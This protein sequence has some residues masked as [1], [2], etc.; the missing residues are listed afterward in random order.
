MLVIVFAVA[1]TIDEAI[2]LA[3]ASDYTLT[4]AVWTSNIYSAQLVTSR[5][6]S[7]KKIFS[8]NMI[9]VIRN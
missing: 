7:G 4:A 3:N 6:R 8:V 1:D 5:V 2:T 9:G